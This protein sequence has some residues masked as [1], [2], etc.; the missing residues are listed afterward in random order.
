M[1]LYL[2]K[3]IN[4][5]DLF[6]KHNEPETTFQGFRGNKFSILRMVNLEYLLKNLFGEAKFIWYNR[7]SLILIT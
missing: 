7:Q 6:K 1:K 5:S 2:C 3:K 4:Q